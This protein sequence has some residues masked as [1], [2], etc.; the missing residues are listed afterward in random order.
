MA[1]LTGGAVAGGVVGGVEPVDVVVAPLAVVGA[2]LA[3]VGAAPLAVVGAAPLA[4][5]G[6]APL[7]VEGVEDDELLPHAARAMAL[8]ARRA[9][10][11]RFKEDPPGWGSGRF[12]GGDRDGLPTEVTGRQPLVR[13]ERRDPR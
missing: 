11:V 6:A 3:V 4:V 5:V 9:G 13:R 12:G 8:A 7:A 2:A 10:T 1:P